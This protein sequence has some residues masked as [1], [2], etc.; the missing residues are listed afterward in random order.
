MGKQT[1]P[2]QQVSGVGNLHGQGPIRGQ[3]AARRCT[4][5]WEKAVEE[6]LPHLVIGCLSFLLDLIDLTCT[7]AGLWVVA[8]LFAPMA[9]SAAT[10]GGGKEGRRVLCAPPLAGLRCRSPEMKSKCN[11]PIRICENSLSLQLLSGAGGGL[12]LHSWEC[13]ATGL[14]GTLLQS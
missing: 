14:K 8:L 10:E 11:L 9:T 6:P 2:A 7:W 12:T 1:W 4:G 3:V 5:I 13:S